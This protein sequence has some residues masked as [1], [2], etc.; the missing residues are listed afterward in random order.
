MTYPAVTAT[1]A[2]L[3]G[4]LFVALSAWVIRG[5]FKFRVLHG[6]GGDRGML[7]RMRAHA[8]F[9]EYVPFCVLI[10][11]LLEVRGAA[12]ST[13]HLLLGPLLVARVA[14]P[15][16]MEAVPNSPQQYALRGAPMVVTL[17]VIAAASVLLVTGV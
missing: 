6:D 15:F 7:R 10:V 17:L 9:A 2:A 8:N 1:Y 16:G 12:P 4:L 3:L 14:H 13:V 5:R 11:G